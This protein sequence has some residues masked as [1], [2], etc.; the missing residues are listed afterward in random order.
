MRHQIK[1][2]DFKR[3]VGNVGLILHVPGI[4][5][6]LSIIVAL[7]FNEEYAVFPFL[8]TFLISI[9]LGQLLYHL[10]KGDGR[11]TLWDSMSIAALSWLLCP[12]LAAI[13]LIWI[14]TLR[15]KMGVHLESS[16]ALMKPIN[17][18]FEAFSGFTA[19]GLTLVKRPSEF[20]HSVIWWR[21]L[22][23]WVGG[24]GL[25]VF[26]LS[27]VEATKTKY[28]LYYAESRTDVMGKTIKETTRTIW[29]LYLFYTIVSIMLFFFSGMPIWDAINH[30]MTGISTGG[31]TITDDSFASYNTAIKIAALFIMLCGAMSF[32]V[33]YQ[34]LKLRKFCMVWKSIPNLTLLL[35]FIIGSGLCIFIDN[36]TLNRWSNIDSIFTW[37]SAMTTSGF[38]VQNIAVHAPMLKVFLVMG[39]IIGGVAGSTAGGI[40]IQRFL[41]LVS[42]MAIRIRAIFDVRSSRNVDRFFESSKPGEEP[43][44]VV[45][46]SEQM[47]KLFGAGV[48][49][50]LWMIAILI[51]WLF[52]TYHV[53]H[54]KA[55]NAFFEIVSATSNVGLSTDIVSPKLSGSCL[56]IFIILMWLGRVEIIPALVMFAAFIKLFSTKKKR[57]K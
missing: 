31:F 56:S 22:M 30:G 37:V 34:V 57:L 13:P 54:E 55:F 21:S 10:C 9:G 33:H 20:S 16:M 14:A 52:V 17:A 48:L 18:L 46:N 28:Q 49:F 41:N 24:V 6:L 25:I 4:M 40:K 51:G 7:I 35:M 44:M 12:I 29:G 47:R 38:S 53:P 42:G 11:S 3:V 23:Q 2:V 45:M 43:G 8:A 15:F 26:I 32:V 36:I 50:F 39:M 5:A 1:V 19:S 27:V